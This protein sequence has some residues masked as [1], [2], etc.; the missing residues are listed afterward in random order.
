MT[1]HC[2]NPACPYRSRHGSPAEFGAGVSACLD[3]GTALVEGGAPTSQ[4]ATARAIPWKQLAITVGAVLVAEALPWIPLPGTE[5]Y[6]RAGLMGMF[7]RHASSI[8]ALGLH[9]FMTAAIL[10]E[11]AAVLIPPLRKL[12]FGGPEQR[13]SLFRATVLL[14][15]LLAAVQ[16]RS[17]AVYLWSLSQRTDY[18]APRSPVLLMLL[19]VG[20]AMTYLGLVEVINRYGFGNGF[21]VLFGVSLL[22]GHVFATVDV[23]Q[24][25]GPMAVISVG[26]PLIGAAA[27]VAVWLFRDRPSAG[28]RL[29]LPSSGAVPLSTATSLLDFGVTLALWFPAL[30][31]AATLS[32]PVRLAFEAV[33]GA[34]LLVPVAWLFHRPKG[35][36]AIWAQYA[37]H[38]RLADEVEARAALRRSLGP[39]AIFLAAALGMQLIDHVLNVPL[40]FNVLSALTLGAIAADLVREWRFRAEHQAVAIWPAQ[41]LDHADAL[42]TALE[43][44]GIPAM[45]QAR[46]LR[47]LLQFFG[48]Y[49]PMQLW[50]PAEQAG[51][52]EVL[53]RERL[54]PTPL[55]NGAPA[56]LQVG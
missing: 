31:A 5:R 38:A 3:C 26:A 10:V 15:G 24:Q 51:R 33:V 19:L 23:F 55:T 43:A 28:E 45:V 29:A 30:G 42:R 21:A 34:A 35:V 40:A 11:L 56:G 41:Q 52:A 12:R 48:P 4:P 37:R 50:V 13:R 16:A 1:R 27:V 14:T 53:L 39:A 8:G 49:A 17:I 47:A 20:T 46:S 36:A 25:D 18:V 9:P 6:P 44:A 7:H 2:P 22:V 32:W 54:Q